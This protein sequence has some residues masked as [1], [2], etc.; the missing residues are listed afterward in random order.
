VSVVCLA[1]IIITV[2]IIL[3][4]WLSADN[5]EEL[6]YIEL[7]RGVD[8]NRA[9]LE[10]NG[11][12]LDRNDAKLDRNDAELDQN[13][14]V[15]DPED[16]RSAGLN[17][18]ARV[19]QHAKKK[20]NKEGLGKILGVPDESQI[21]YKPNK[22]GQFDCLFSK[23]TIQYE[24]LNDDFCDCLDGSDEPSTSACSSGHFYCLS[25]TKIPSSRVNDGICDC[26]DG[27]DEYRREVVISKVGRE[28]QG[29]I[30]HY[31]SPCGNTC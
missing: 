14:A 10:R 28:M 4:S 16:R 6:R 2:Q 15:L 9:V 21:R 20:F 29:R 5:Q 12:V 8:R 17:K 7:N 31:L 26:C 25:G 18:V 3:M 24:R 22:E 30:R 23:Q 27:T 13:G 11:A 19:A 1:T